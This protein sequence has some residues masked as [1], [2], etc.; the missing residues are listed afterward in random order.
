MKRIFSEKEKSLGE[1]LSGEDS[2][3]LG[4]EDTSVMTANTLGIHISILQMQIHNLFPTFIIPNLRESASEKPLPWV[5]Q[6]QHY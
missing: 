6:S 5:S 1:R 3:Y 2:R 4:R